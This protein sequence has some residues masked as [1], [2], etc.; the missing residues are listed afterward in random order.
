MTTAMTREG[1]APRL[2]GPWL[3]TNI[4]AGLSQH[5]SEYGALPTNAA[6]WLVEAAT[7][8]GLR[9]RGGA[10]FPTGRKLATVA[11]N[12]AQAGGA[13]VIVNGAESEPAA[14]KDKLLLRVAPHLVLDGAELA[15][16]AVGAREVTVCV[17]R[18]AGLLPVLQGAIGER[19]AAGWGSGVRLSAV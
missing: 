11:T 4:P 10:W 6:P 19:A 3:R 12:G 5:G 16:L 17:H 13:Y 2:L 7:K 14:S 1:Q 18:G 8:A 9:G 15:A